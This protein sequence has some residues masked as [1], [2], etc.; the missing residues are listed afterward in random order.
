MKKVYG[1]IFL[2]ININS[3]AQGNFNF[4]LSQNKLT[5]EIL[6][7]TNLSLI[8]PTININTTKKQN[9]KKSYVFK[10]KN[11][12]TDYSVW[13]RDGNV[14]S[15]IE[16]IISNKSSYLKKY[17]GIDIREKYLIPHLKENEDNSEQILRATTIELY[18]QRVFNHHNM[19]K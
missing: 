7:K 5:D 11:S 3:F 18:L 14:F 12:Y 15:E 17:L 8:N 1:I 9:E 4:K 10:N 16:K 6:Y 13:I 2:V 19:K